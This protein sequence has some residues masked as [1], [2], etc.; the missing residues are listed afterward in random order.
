MKLALIAFLF[1]L[2]VAAVPCVS[3]IGPAAAGEPVAIVEE[4]SAGVADLQPMS[5]LESGRQFVLGPGDSVTLGY[6]K[7]CLR[8]IIT[9]GAVLVGDRGSTVIG[10]VALRHESTDCDGGRLQLSAEEAGK[11]GVTVFRATPR[12]ENG[13]ALPEHEI[14]LFG[15]SPVFDVAGAPDVVVER[16]DRPGEHYEL[17]AGHSAALRG[18][19]YDFA[20]ARLALSPGGLYRATSGARQI[21]FRVDPFAASGESPIP[22]RLIRF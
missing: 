20:R 6:L 18:N 10:A 14:T 9:G 17:V 11:G 4:I 8:E 7:S 16:L 13:Q 5:Y 19:F 12:G 1:G 15:L 21:V 2:I 3:L 22:G